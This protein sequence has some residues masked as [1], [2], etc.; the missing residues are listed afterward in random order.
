MSGWRSWRRSRSARV[1]LAGLDA[2]QEQALVDD[3]SLLL[4]LYLMLNRW[5]QTE[6]LAHYRFTESEWTLLLAR[7]DRMGV[8]ELL[9]GNRTRPRT[10]RNFRWRRE[11]PMQAFFQRTLLP[12]FFR[13]AFD[14]E[15]D[16]LLLL[17]GMLSPP[18][19]RRSTEGLASW[20]RNSTS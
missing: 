18:L 17:S 14:G 2:G 7:L 19:Q 4:A 20:L 8:I 13:R 11:G 3:P 1:P 6:V 9:P 5:Q 10:A 12:E 16:R 15:Q